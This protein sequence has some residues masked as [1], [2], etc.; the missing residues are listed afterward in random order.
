MLQLRCFGEHENEL[1]AVF[2]HNRRFFGHGD[3]SF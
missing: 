1:F 3:C 2:D